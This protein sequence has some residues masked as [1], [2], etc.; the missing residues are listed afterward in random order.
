MKTITIIRYREETVSYDG[1]C[2]G[3]S[4]FDYNYYDVATD[5]LDAIALILAK[6]HFEQRFDEIVV[7]FD[8]VPAAYTVDDDEKITS[9]YS[10][11]DDCKEWLIEDRKKFIAE[12]KRKEEAKKKRAKELYEKRKVEREK[13][14]LVKLQEKYG[15]AVT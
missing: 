7:L 14:Q 2:D 10:K 5:G 6:Y 11:V 12:E 4:N 8:G 15:N 1:V 9:F 13:K 3:L